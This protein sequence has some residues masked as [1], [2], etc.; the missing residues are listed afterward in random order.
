MYNWGYIH[1]NNNYHW[2][3]YFWVNLISNGGGGPNSSPS[4]TFSRLNITSRNSLH[5]PKYIFSKFRNQKFKFCMGVP[6][7]GILE[8]AEIYFSKNDQNIFASD[9]IFLLQ[10]PFY[11]AVLFPTGLRVLPAGNLKNATG[12]AFWCEFKVRPP[13]F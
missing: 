2:K 13:W 12:N 7:S 4:T 6:L 10:N 11:Q 8:N 1:N 3:S 9:T 5:F